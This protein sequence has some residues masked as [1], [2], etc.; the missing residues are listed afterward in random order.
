MT[1]RT[2]NNNGGL[3]SCGR[4]GD[5]L[6]K[7]SLSKCRFVAAWLCAR[8]RHCRV[9][10]SYSRLFSRMPRVQERGV[11]LCS[12]S[13]GLSLCSRQVAWRPAYSAAHVNARTR[14]K[15]TFF[16]AA[17]FSGSR[18]NCG[19]NAYHQTLTAFLVVTINE[20]CCQVKSKQILHRASPPT[21]G[22]A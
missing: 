18:L 6:I 22:A 15:K 12:G 10:C 9:V 20:K 3:L 4:A 17:A 21:A 13:C 5:E 16:I 2:T 11:C 14:E 19:L 1:R 7:A 8:P